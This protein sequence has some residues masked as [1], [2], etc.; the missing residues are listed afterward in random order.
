MKIII[1][2]NK[3]Q[4]EDFLRKNKLLKE[5]FKYVSEPHQIEGLKLKLVI[6]TGTY[7][8]NKMWKDNSLFDWLKVN[9]ARFGG[10]IYW[11]VRTD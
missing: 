11:D 5:H 4:Y 6:F 1:A 2:G 9:V 7:W 3:H 10:R 8:E